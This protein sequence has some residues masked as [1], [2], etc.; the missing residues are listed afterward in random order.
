MG[1]AVVGN[2]TANC[3]RPGNHTKFGFR[4]FSTVDF[5]LG[6]NTE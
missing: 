3:V 5:M 2:L 4:E 1:I 6:G